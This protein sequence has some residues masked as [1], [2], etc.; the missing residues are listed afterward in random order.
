M[1]T[2][3]CDHPDGFFQFYSFPNTANCHSVENESSYD[4]HSVFICHRKP[5]LSLS[6]GV[7]QA[8]DNV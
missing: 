3:Y 5:G 8:A 6:T 1:L 4:E 2:T 7:R